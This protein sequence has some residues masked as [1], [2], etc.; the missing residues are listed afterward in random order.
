MTRAHRRGFTL[1][2]VLIALF[3]IALGVGA[4]LAT[5]TSS[6]DAAAHLREKS[7]AEW[8]ALNRISEVRLANTRPGPGTTSGT[9]EFAGRTWRWQQTVNDPGIA[10]I[11]RLD[12]MVA[13]QSTAA[14]P[15][16]AAD[17]LG[18]F[19]ALGRAIGFIGMSVAPSDGNLPDWSLAAA[20]APPGGPG[21][22]GGQSGSGAPG[23]PG[24]PG[25]GAP[26]PGGLVP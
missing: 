21:T 6:A 13:P 19:P 7:L 15:A 12:V 1:I 20:P 16:A 2:E 5:L 14:Q 25:G 9:V 26:A 17:D 24:T 10:G 22:P 3:V 18:G 11:R 23:G 4:L 8:I